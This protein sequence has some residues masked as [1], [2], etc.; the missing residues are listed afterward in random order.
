VAMSSTSRVL[1]SEE[2][3]GVAPIWWRGGGA[4]SVPPSVSPQIVRPKPQ[5]SD[6]DSERE[7]IERDA[8]E[9][10][11]AE[12]QALG[13][14]QAAAE[15]APVLDRLGRALVSLSSM[16]SRIRKDAEKELLALAI[17]IARRVVHRELTLDPE[18][19]GGLIKVA[20]EKLQA[21]EV[22]RVHVNPAQEAAVRSSLDRFSTAHKIEVVTDSSLQSGDLLFE[23]A[24]GTLDASIDA[25][26]REIERGFADRLQR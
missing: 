5:A 2:L 25:Q 8:H 13:K 9:R 22:C 10:G 3:S 26:L 23:T 6:P 19:M 24:H 11:F 4:A 18:S 16:R 1:R 21:R 15:L 20:L 7:R 12:G 14:E 17:A